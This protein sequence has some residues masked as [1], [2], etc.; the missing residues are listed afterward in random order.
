MKKFSV[1]PIITYF[2][3][4]Y[5]LYKSSPQYLQ[6][7]FNQ[8]LRSA[9]Y[10]THP[11]I[12]AQLYLSKR[13]ANGFNITQRFLYSQKTRET[14]LEIQDTC[15]KAGCPFYTYFQE[16]SRLGFLYCGCYG[17]VTL[18]GSKLGFFYFLNHSRTKVQKR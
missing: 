9:N 10:I 11:F 13:V 12:P 5:S 2:T 14:H 4:R 3:R 15:F 16:M 8:N 6:A 17:L 1:F 18:R 7:V